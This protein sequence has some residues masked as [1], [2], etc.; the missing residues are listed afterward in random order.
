MDGE[1][2]VTGLLEAECKTEPPLS[3]LPTISG[4]LLFNFN[5]CPAANLS[6][7]SNGRLEEEG[8][9]EAQKSLPASSTEKLIQI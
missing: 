5:K 1:S 8:K 3:V 6:T 7:A 4:G 2:L 9:T